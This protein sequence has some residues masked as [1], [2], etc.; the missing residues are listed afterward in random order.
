[1]R[2]RLMRSISSTTSNGLSSNVRLRATI[3]RS[4]AK[5]RGIAFHEVASRHPHLLRVSS[6]SGALQ[7][8]VQPVLVVKHQQTVHEEAVEPGLDGN[9]S[10]AQ[11]EA[12]A[13]TGATEQ[14]D[15]VEGMNIGGKVGLAGPGGFADSL[16]G[17]IVVEGGAEGAGRAGPRPRVPRLRR[18]GEGLQIIAGE[19]RLRHRLCGLRVAA[20]GRTGG[21]R[22]P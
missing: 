18:Q 19:R 21:S 14:G 2:M 11:G 8:T 3:A 10:L 15:A 13:A 5:L 6:V 17:A 16:E 7:G 9:R 1:M 22:V 20:G 4:S 12:Q